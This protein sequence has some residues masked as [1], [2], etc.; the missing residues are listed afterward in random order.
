M[1]Q[2]NEVIEFRGVIE[3]Q[4]ALKTFA[5]DLHKEM[6]K[7][8]NAAVGEVV[9]AAKRYVVREPGNLFNWPGMITA[10]N[11]R[12]WQEAIEGIR[13]FPKW[14]VNAVKAGI[15]K[16]VRQRGQ[17]F[18]QYGFKISA[19]A[20]NMTAAGSVY[21]FAGRGRPPRNNRS[22]NP[23][24]SEFFKQR[25]QTEYLVPPGSKGRGRLVFRAGFENLGNA[26]NRINK[27]QYNADQK[28][29]ARLKATDYWNING[30][31]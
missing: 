2:R 25:M 8:I 29:Q 24:A 15:K 30:T 16:R 11:P 13:P 14:D 31:V 12:T 4:Q 6:M 3:T 20:Q 23:R 22:D 17:Y 1:A 28:L 7:E 9:T 26:R 5:P 18:N 27:A 19:A 10:Y 21:E